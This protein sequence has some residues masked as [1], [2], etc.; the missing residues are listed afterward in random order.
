[1]HLK[2]A[3][4]KIL[5]STVTLFVAGIATL[6]TSSKTSTFIYKYSLTA[7]VTPVL[8]RQ[9][10]LISVVDVCKLSVEVDHRDLHCR[11]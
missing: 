6:S 7:S 1:M 11:S 8:L 10:L 9:L 4:W 5:N 2:V 3:T